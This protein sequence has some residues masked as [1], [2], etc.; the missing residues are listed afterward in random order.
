MKTAT[1]QIPDRD[2]SLFLLLAEKFGAKLEHTSNTENNAEY[3]RITEI[4][5]KGGDFSY[6]GDILEWQKEQRK[7]RK[8]P[9]RD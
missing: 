4:I 5:K 3:N 8:L 6:L 1:F 7:D 2:F 9:F